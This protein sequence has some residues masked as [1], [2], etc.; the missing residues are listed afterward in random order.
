VMALAWR[1]I[2]LLE[3]KLFFRLRRNLA[4][5]FSQQATVCARVWPMLRHPRRLRVKVISQDWPW[6][7]M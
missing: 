4:I 2:G 3:K 6:I 5:V 7:E 1:T